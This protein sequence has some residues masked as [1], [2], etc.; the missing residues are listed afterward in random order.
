VTIVG[1]VMAVFGAI[2]ILVG[3]VVMLFMGALGAFL[4]AFFPFSEG[5]GFAGFF[6]VLGIIAA[7][8]VFG[9]AA[10]TI[11]TGVGALR[12]RSWAWIAMLVLMGLNALRGLAGLA[13]RDIGSVVTLAVSGLVIWY[14]FTPE[15]KTWFGRA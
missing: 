1:L 7:M 13:Q 6:G 3:M 11:A 10:V 4:G 5:A 8:F 2:A 14:F 15:V 12:G 9:F